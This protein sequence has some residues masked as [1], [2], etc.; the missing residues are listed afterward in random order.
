MLIDNYIYCHKCENIYFC[1]NK[2]EQDNK[3]HLKLCQSISD[4][5]RQHR[6]KILKTGTYS[7]T[8]TVN[9][10]RTVVSL[11]GKRSLLSHY[12]N[13][14]PPTLLLDP[15]AQVSI[16]NIKKFANNF[17]HV[18][19]QYIS[20]ILDDYDTIMIQWGDDK[21]ISFKGWV[22]MKVKIG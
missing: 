10:N 20:L 1:N 21:D 8:F 15:G 13:D 18:K 3:K 5:Q 14:Q 11:V 4:L 2:C 19:I 22:G 9:E 12:L 16:I 6:D 17:P 7:T